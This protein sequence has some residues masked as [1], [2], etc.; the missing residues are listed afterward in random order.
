MISLKNCVMPQSAVFD[1]YEHLTFENCKLSHYLPFYFRLHRSKDDSR[2]IASS[3]TEPKKV[4]KM[5]Q[6]EIY[7]VDIYFNI[8]EAAVNIEIIKSDLKPSGI[9]FNIGN[10][11]ACTQEETTQSVTFVNVKI[12]KCNILLIRTRAFTAKFVAVIQVIDSIIDDDGIVEYEHDGAIEYIIDNCTFTNIK[13]H[14]FKSFAQYVRITNSK[15]IIYEDDHFCSE[16]GC[17]INVKGTYHPESEI[18]DEIFNPSCQRQLTCSFVQVENN[19][20]VGSTGVTPGGVIRVENIWLKITNSVFRLTEHSS[21]P[22]TGGIIFISAKYHSFDTDNVTID[23]RKLTEVGRVS[24]ISMKSWYTKFDGTEILCAQ[25][26]KTDEK[27]KDKNDFRHYTCLPACPHGEYTYQSGTM[28]L[29]GKSTRWSPTSLKAQNAPP[30][31][32][33]CPVGANCGERVS[34]LPN[35]WGY[36]SAENSTVNML[37][38]PNG[39]CCQ[40]T[41]GC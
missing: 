9:I 13:A 38:C 8:T 20:F 24:V 15:F 7:T 41:N 34:A 14:G 22:Q 17:A 16:G 11:T 12:V 6:C 21:P 3:S 36:R 2:Q 30:F 27:I 35:Y 37:R 23:A 33:L 39:Y 4:L 25:G 28:L 1:I 40:D 32:H 5:I 26:M 29:S 18:L 31:C 19:E 10:E